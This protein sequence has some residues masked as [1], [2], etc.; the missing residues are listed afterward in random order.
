MHHP[1]VAGIPLGLLE[2]REYEE[3]GFQAQPGDLIVLYSDGVED[4]LNP[5]GEE[6]GR[7]GLSRLLERR[8][9]EPAQVI[10]DAIFKDLD[11]FAEGTA[12]TDDQTLIVMRVK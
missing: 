12:I 5:D 11:R 4:Q 6:Y 1:R 3:V 7:R 8:W 2:E 9:Q 10:A